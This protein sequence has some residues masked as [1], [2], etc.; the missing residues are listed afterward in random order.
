MGVGV[1]V[2]AVGAA[3]YLNAN[4][5][6]PG[7]FVCVLVMLQGPLSPYEQWCLSGIRPC[8]WL[9]VEMFVC[10]YACMCM[11]V[12]SYVLRVYYGKMYLCSAFLT[13]GQSKFHFHFHSPI[14][15]HVHPPTAVSPTHWDRQLIGS[16]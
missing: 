13:S 4:G 3:N 14:H 2:G 16:S 12:Y 6:V 8:V 11:Y 10:T 1:P 9:Y 15:A 5:A 7:S